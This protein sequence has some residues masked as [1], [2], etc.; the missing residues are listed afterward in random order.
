MTDPVTNSGTEQILPT[1]EDACRKS[2]APDLIRL[3][4]AI[5]DVVQ[6]LTA[7]WIHRPSLIQ[8]P[9]HDPRAMQVN[10]PAG[11]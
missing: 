2:P 5:A 1:F 8:P 6:R 11:S 3:G 4:L 10:T 9:I 7:R